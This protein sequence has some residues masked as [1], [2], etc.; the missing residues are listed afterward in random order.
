MFAGCERRKGLHPQQRN[1]NRCR[2]VT[3]HAVWDGDEPVPNKL[4]ASSVKV[5]RPAGSIDGLALFQL[6]QARPHLKELR[7]QAASFNSP[8]SGQWNFRSLQKLHVEF[9]QLDH[10]H[11]VDDFL[12]FAERLYLNEL[13]LTYTG[14]GFAS[15]HG[16]SLAKLHFDELH[17]TGFDIKQSAAL[18][19]KNAQLTDCIL[20]ISQTDLNIFYNAGPQ[21][22][23]DRCRLPQALSWRMYGL[24]A[25][26]CFFMYFLASA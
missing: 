13:H 7:I 6:C 21:L 14:S 19:D 9:D 8:M 16:S 18:A 3:K 10:D 11:A 4:S 22:V 5:K 15:L 26:V 25:A 2:A 23:L 1:V 24:V 17:I 12:Q 20:D